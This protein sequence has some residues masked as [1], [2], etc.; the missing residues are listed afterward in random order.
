M[1]IC[2]LCMHI[3]THK[4][5]FAHTRSMAKIEG[6]LLWRQV[7]TMLYMLVGNLYAQAML[8]TLPS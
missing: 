3:H 2:V 6:Y 7:L 5:T 8:S 4:Y 1:L